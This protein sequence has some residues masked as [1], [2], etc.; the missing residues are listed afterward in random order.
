MLQRLEVVKVKSTHPIPCIYYCVDCYDMPGLKHQV[1]QIFFDVHVQ[2]KIQNLEHFTIQYKQLRKEGVGEM[3]KS[4]E[5]HVHA[6][7]I[8][9]QE[10][11][12]LLST[13]TIGLHNPLADLWAVFY[14]NGKD[15]CL[16]G[17]I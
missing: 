10:E 5:I 4:A 17:G 15:F 2:L 11:D 3:A 6:H 16:S 12:K 1:F 14:Y 7:V 8:T 13:E 9:K